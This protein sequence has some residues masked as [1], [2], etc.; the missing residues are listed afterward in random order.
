MYYT[1]MDEPVGP[2]LYPPVRDDPSNDVTHCMAQHIIGD[3]MQAF[4]CTC[5][6][7]VAQLVYMSMPGGIQRIRDKMS[8]DTISPDTRSPDSMSPDN[9]SPDKMSPDKISTSCTADRMSPFSNE[10]IRPS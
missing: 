6:L 10:Y 5:I 7:Y 3:G 4:Q 8:P 1:Q 9:M 2:T